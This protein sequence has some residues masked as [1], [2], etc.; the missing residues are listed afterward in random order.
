[1]FLEVKDLNKGFGDKT[2][3]IEVLKNLS[4]NPDFRTSFSII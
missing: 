4:L 1:M 2:N 3:R